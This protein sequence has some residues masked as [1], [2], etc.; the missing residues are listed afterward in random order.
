MKRIIILIFILLFAFS[1]R[2]L[3]AQIETIDLTTRFDDR[4]LVE[5]VIGTNCT[6]DFDLGS[7]INQ[8]Y[9]RYYDNGTAVRVYGGNTITV[10]ANSMLISEIEF[11]FGTGGNHNEITASTGS[12]SNGI[13]TGE[14]TEV[15]FQ[16]AGNSGH[17]RLQQLTITYVGEVAPPTFNLY[18]ASTTFL[19]TI[20]VRIEAVSDATIRY[21]TDGST[22]TA[23]STQFINNLTFNQTTTLK[24]IAIKN[25]R[26][27]NVATL[28]LVKDADLWSGTGTRIDPFIID[29][30]AKLD[31]LATRVNSGETYENT[32]FK[33]TADIEY[34]YTSAWNDITSTENNYTCIGT[35]NNNFNG[36]FD[37]GG[38]TVSGIRVYRLSSYNHGLF[39]FIGSRAIVKNITLAD[40]RLTV[41]DCGAGIVGHCH[42]TIENCHVAAN[43]RIHDKGSGNYHGGIVGRHYSGSVIRC[44]C[45]ATL[46]IDDGINPG[47]Y[48][49]I[50]GRSEGGTVS[51]CLAI[52]VKLPEASRFSENYL[53]QRNLGAIAGVTQQTVTECLYYDCTFGNAAADNGLGRYSGSA[54]PNEARLSHTLS[55]A[56]EGVSL[57]F[58]DDDPNPD[59]VE[60]YPFGLAYGGVLY[61]AEND[62]VT[63]SLSVPERFSP[64]NV[65][66]SSG[67][68]TDNGN[69]T[70][71][72]TMPATD[73]T[74]SATLVVGPCEIRYELHDSYGDGWEDAAIQV[75]DVATE[76]ILAT[77]TVSSGNSASGTLSVNNG[78]AIQFQW[79]N[80]DFDSECSYTVYD[81]ID[82]VIFSGQNAMSAPVNYTVN[83]NPCPK[84]K[85]LN[86]ADITSVSATLSWTGSSDHYNVRYQE[87]VFYDGFENGLNNWTV[88]RNGEGNERT[89]WICYDATN[90]NDSRISNHGGSYVARSRSWQSG[91]PFNVDNWLITPQVALDG[92]LRFWVFDDGENHEHYDVY[93][94]T[95]STNI[96][97]F[98]LLYAPGNA[99]NTW[100]EVVV[101]LSTFNG[102]PGYIALRNTDYD[103]DSLLID[104]F[105][106]YTARPDTTVNTN[107]IEIDG[108]TPETRYLCQVQGACDDERSESDWSDIYFTTISACD[109][110]TGLETTNILSDGATFNWLNSHESYTVRYRKVVFSEGFE[111][112]IPTSWTK[113]DSDGDGN[114]WLALSEIPTVYNN[115]PY[116]DEA[117]YW[118]HSGNDAASSPSYVNNYGAFDS[119]H[120]LITPQIELPNTLTFYAKS[121]YSDLDEYEVLLS[122][123]GTEPS[124]FTI[125]LRQMAPAPEDW[126]RVSIDLSQYEGQAGYIA[127]H[128]VQYDGYFLIIDDFFFDDEWQTANVSE[129]ML[130][131]SGLHANTCYEWQ[132]Q[133]VNCDG[134]GHNTEWS[135][136]VFFTTPLPSVNVLANQWYA[137]AAP[138]HDDNVT[139]FDI[140]HVTGLTDN[141]YDF[142]RYNEEEGTWENQRA[143]GGTA[144]RFTT[145]NPGRG[146]IYRRSTDATLTFTGIF[147]SDSY[148]YTLTSLCPDNSIKGFNLIGNPYPHA[149]YKGVSFPATNLTAGFY[150]LNP[151]GIWHAR[152]DNEPIAVCQAVLVK[153]AGNSSVALT[154]TDNGDAPTDTKSSQ[155][156]ILAFAVHGKDYED[157]AYATFNNSG[158]GLPKIGHLNAEAPMLSIPQEGRH[159]AI[160]RFDKGTTEFPL[161]FSGKSGEYTIS[162]PSTTKSISYL[163][164]LDRLT[165]A[166]I[167]LLQTPTYAFSSTG[168][169][170]GRFLVKLSPDS[171]NIPFAYQSGN[172]LIVEGT[173]TLQA[174][175]IMGRLL[176]SRKVN[177][178]LSIPNSQFPSTGVY[179]LRLNENMQ[180]IVVK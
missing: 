67:T 123:T 10:T 90:F 83:C 159:Y 29:N 78:Q 68:L 137:I 148:S 85:D 70:Y 36:V 124:D 48:G 5:S 104:D 138:T 113:I 96:E 34:T 145:F 166:D 47:D 89:D 77:W 121:Q 154:F 50:I 80:G 128:H 21:T 33:V 72:L 57:R 42:G 59:V 120:W 149:I 162:I 136:S 103:K 49:G 53:H 108:L 127:I 175:D 62:N 39:A 12:Y 8:V 176:F 35:S 30:T 151:N 76:T 4:E 95:S 38:H 163:H 2:L 168:N 119:D 160:A 140:A 133:G 97:D 158:S 122:I 14:A 87:A 43:V 118:S 20:E 71:T 1:P 66:A 180:K 63:F 139:T 73:V 69:G 37:G 98:T 112:G 55:C 15:T 65:S 88:I 142:F 152:L 172:T 131:I 132:V 86:V 105:G 177:S 28:L 101:D 60:D 169:D 13:W 56:T 178:Q 126:E 92:V 58:D 170:A 7:N 114:N 46:S 155:P 18:G 110:P 82:D 141:D 32:Y 61:A 102:T 109:A 40:S 129:N 22:P 174:Y 19:N 17:R 99:T 135:E 41:G 81:A 16:V 74:V 11:S 161:S 171:D 164:L 9:P 91:N 94:S 51:H 84:A 64:S 143:S 153:V 79:I 75:V 106:I 173:G 25:G 117:T 134:D 130:T 179:I 150:S 44:T 26:T 144:E 125:V 31:Q 156:A 165:G 27:S 100:T 116:I 147:N 167:N 111:E 52:Q 6:I 146:Y 24:A 157:I 93:V 54:N 45:A 107:S 23:I 115:D 3:K